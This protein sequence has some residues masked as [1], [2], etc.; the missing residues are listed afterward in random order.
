MNTDSYNINMTLHN[1]NNNNFQSLLEYVDS[2]GNE[3]NVCVEGDD[4][5]EVIQT[6][7]DQTVDELI[8]L[9]EQ[10]DFDEE[11]MTDEEYIEFLEEELSKIREERDELELVLQSYKD[12]AK[13]RQDQYDD[14]FKELI[15]TNSLKDKYYYYFDAL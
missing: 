4:L 11:D 13:K 6:I 15:K 14:F 9:A 1:D 7:Y 10:D 8:A 12:K 3:V 5:E 2:E